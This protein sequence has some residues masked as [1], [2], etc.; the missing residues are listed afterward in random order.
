M[1]TRSMCFSWFVR[2]IAMAGLLC[3]AASYTSV[4]N[5]AQ[6]CGQGFHRGA[7]GG[8]VMNHLGPNATVAPAHPGCWRN[9]N[10]YLRC[11]AR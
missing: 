7:Y 3:V 1:N 5:A 10:G 11:P 4:A 6:G 9:G 2:G 8:C